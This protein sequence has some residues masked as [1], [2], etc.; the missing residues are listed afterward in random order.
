MFKIISF[1]IITLF[2]QL[3]V[4]VGIMF[5]KLALSR[6]L[7]LMYLCQPRKVNGAYLCVRGTYFASF[8]NYDN[9][10]WNCSD[11]VVFFVFHFIGKQT[12]KFAFPVYQSFKY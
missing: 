1:F 2:S 3:Y 5:I 6:H 7:L 8:Y 10:I 4:K 11:S 12:S 9:W